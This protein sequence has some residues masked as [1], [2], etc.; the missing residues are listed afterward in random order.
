[1]SYTYLAS[2]Y[3]HAEPAMREVRYHA[4]MKCCAWLLKNRVWVYSPI[5]YC[6]ELARLH[7]M[8]TNAHFWMDY[9]YAM[10]RGAKDLLILVLPG[11]Q[12]SVGIDNEVE[13]AHAANKPIRFIHPSS[14]TVTD[15]P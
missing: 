4:A 11:W 5:V 7:D 8:P 13:Y 2:P 15:E 12:D 10:L 3:T 6:H 9:N 14:Y 1:M